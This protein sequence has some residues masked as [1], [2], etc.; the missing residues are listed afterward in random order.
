MYVAEAEQQMIDKH[1]ITLSGPPTTVINT[2]ANYGY[3]MRYG[4]DGNHYVAHGNNHEIRIYN[5]TT[6]A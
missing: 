4:P 3:G 6:S 2:G 1:N 5:G